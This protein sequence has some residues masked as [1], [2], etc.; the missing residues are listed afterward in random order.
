MRQSFSNIETVPQKLMNMNKSKICCIIIFYLDQSTEALQNVPCLQK[1]VRL[2]FMLFRSKTVP[3]KC[4]GKLNSMTFWFEFCIWNVRYLIGLQW[5]RC[6]SPYLCRVHCQTI[7]C[8]TLFC[9]GQLFKVTFFRHIFL[10]SSNSIWNLAC[11]NF[12]HVN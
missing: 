6:L 4:A 12:A 11:Y 3:K 10:I 7:A 2:F 8:V 5:S 9:F 1:I